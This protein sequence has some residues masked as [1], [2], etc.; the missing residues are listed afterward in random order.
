M[1]AAREAGEG[2]LA[3]AREVLGRL[4]SGMPADL[5]WRFRNGGWE[6]QSTFVI[7][8]STGVVMLLIILLVLAAFLGTHGVGSDE[9]YFSEDF[10]TFT[11][12]L[13][14]HT[15]QLIFQFALAVLPRK[16]VH[17]RE[18]GTAPPTPPCGRR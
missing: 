18:A 2:I 9:P 1:H 17:R 11:R 6:M 12:N 10:P 3:T 5:L 15:R 4:A 16:V 14:E 8:R 13:G 7:E